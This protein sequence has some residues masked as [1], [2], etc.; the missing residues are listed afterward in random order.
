M[1][2]EDSP[3]A[4]TSGSRYL[5]EGFRQEPDFRD[6]TAPTVPVVTGTPVSSSESTIAIAKRGTSPGL[7]FVF[8][9]PEDGE[10][11]R[12]R[13]LVHGLWEVVLMLALAGLGFLLYR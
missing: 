1:A 2:F 3:Q 10:P 7:E 8:D 6:T 5:G 13:M 11:G 4:G 12:D 9:D